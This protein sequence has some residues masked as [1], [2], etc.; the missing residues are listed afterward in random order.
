MH[1]HIWN[2]YKIDVVNNRLISWVRVPVSISPKQ[3]FFIHIGHLCLIALIQQT[4]RHTFRKRTALRPFGKERRAAADMAHVVKSF[5]AR[6]LHRNKITLIQAD[7]RLLFVLGHMEKSCRVG[8]DHPQVHFPTPVIHPPLIAVPGDLRLGHHLIDTVEHIALFD[9]LIRD[10]VL[11]GQ[12]RFCYI[13]PP[14]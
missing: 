13:D 1:W 9:I 12:N 3:I 11:K 5:D 7:N 8:S 2:L 4:V 10:I 6:V 14:F